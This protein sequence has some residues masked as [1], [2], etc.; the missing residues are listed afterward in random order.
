M[1]GSERAAVRA[2][3]IQAGQR[4]SSSTRRSASPS[5]AVAVGAVAEGAVVGEKTTWAAGWP[6]KRRT[7]VPGP[8]AARR[9]A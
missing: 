6:V 3:H 9:T 4:T 1:P 2:G 7:R 5:Q 8:A